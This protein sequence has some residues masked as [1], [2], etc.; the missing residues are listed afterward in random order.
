[1]CN[2]LGYDGTWADEPELGDHVGRAIWA[3]GT[4]SATGHIPPELREQAATLLDN[5]VPLAGRL[6]ADSPRATAYAIL[7]L[8][9]HP[10]HRTVLA[11][12]V[13]TLDAAWRASA[14]PEWCW[15]AP[16]WPTTTPGWRR[17]CWPGP[18]C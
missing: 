2:M 11:G 8:L 5:L 7:G 9:P 17:P 4:I 13:D 16:G 15:P 18:P 3:A 1:M 12:L 14:T 10:R 6:P